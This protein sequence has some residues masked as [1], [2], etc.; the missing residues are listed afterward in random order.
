M[1]LETA[2]QENTKAIMHLATIW[3]SLGT[4]AAAI[5]T[6][7]EDTPPSSLTAAWTSCTVKALVGTPVATIKEKS[8]K[9]GLKKPKGEHET[10][11]VQ[12]AEQE[13]V[14]TTGTI[15]VTFATVRGLALK[16]AGANRDAIKAL[17]VKYGIPKLS[18][19]LTDEND[20]DS[21]VTDQAKLEGFY[22]DLSALEA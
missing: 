11:H 9:E 1:S 17:N 22:A 18:A 10:E 5:D 6:M 20:L 15:K 4:K 16:L 2:I 19:L 12:N 8:V 13:V 21:E 14:A 3:A 7:P